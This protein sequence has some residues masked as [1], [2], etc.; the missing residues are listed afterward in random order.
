MVVLAVKT[1][2]YT[3]LSETSLNYNHQMLT[4]FHELLTAPN[5]KQFSYVLAKTFFFKILRM[6]SLLVYVEDEALRDYKLR[7]VALAERLFEVERSKCLAIGNSGLN[8]LREVEKEELLAP[9]YIHLL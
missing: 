8:V 2:D 4:F 5:N 3:D 6:L 7:L 9:L 1:I